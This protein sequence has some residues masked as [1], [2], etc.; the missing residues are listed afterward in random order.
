MELLFDKQWS[1]LRKTMEK[2]LPSKRYE[3][4][5][6]V[7]YLAVSIAMCY[8]QDIKKAALAGLLHDCAKYL[9]DTEIRNECKKYRIEMSDTEQRNPYLLHAKLGAYYAQ[10]NYQITDKEILSA[11]IFHTTGKS[12]M[13]FLEKTIFLADYLELFRKQATIP[14]LSELRS[15]V[16]SDLDQ[17]VYLVL[18]NTVQYLKKQSGEIDQT[19]IFALKY[20]ENVVQMN[21]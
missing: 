12:K 21:Q 3:H 7:A 16:F 13:T 5:L 6:S 9:S 1:E 20:Y 8:K 15:M 14:E 17:T 4:S 10:N 11:I 2:L 19:T 18:K